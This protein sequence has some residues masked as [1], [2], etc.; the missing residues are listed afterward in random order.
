MENNEKTM[1]MASFLADSLALGA[2]WIYDTES[3][4]QIFGRV[5]SLLKPGPHSYHPTKEKGEFTHYG[6]QTLVLLESLAEKRDFD[7]SDFNH[8]PAFR[9]SP[10]PSF[11]VYNPIMT[12]MLSMQWK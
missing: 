3:I 7:I 10:T 4:S 5:D 2:H 12:A 1:V 11:S 9:H 8:F 6:D